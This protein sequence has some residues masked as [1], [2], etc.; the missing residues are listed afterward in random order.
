MISAKELK[1]F[2]ETIGDD[3]R[4]AIDEGGLTLEVVGRSSVYIEVGGLPLDVDME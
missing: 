3:E 4:V 2:L 1:A